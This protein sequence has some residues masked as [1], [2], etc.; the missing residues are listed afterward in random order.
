MLRRTILMIVL[1]A[2]LTVSGPGCCPFTERDAALTAASFYKETMHTLIAARRAGSISD[3][4]ARR[5]EPFREAAR[6]AVDSWL[7]GES[8]HEAAVQ[9]VDALHGLVLKLIEDRY[10]PTTGEVGDKS[11]GAAVPS[12][13]PVPFR[14]RGA[15]RRSGYARIV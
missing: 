10:E 7:E 12:P 2:S 9:A 3:E 4:E 8:S 14:S 5:I 15:A 13:P 1:A 6:T 11:A